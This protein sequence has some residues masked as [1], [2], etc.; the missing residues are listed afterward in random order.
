M[1]GSALINSIVRV[2]NARR[3][4]GRSS[5]YPWYSL[6]AL[7]I[8]RLE[9]PGWGRLAKFGLFGME[10]DPLWQGAPRRVVRGKWHGYVMDLDLSDWSQRQTYFL[11]R[12]HELDMQLLLNRCVRAG[13]RVVDVGANIGMVTL[14]AARIVGPHG[15][16]EAFEPNPICCDQI[17][18]L[19][20]QNGIGQVRLHRMGLSDV[21]DTLTLSVL[22]HHSGMGTLGRVTDPRTT[23]TNTFPVPVGIADEVLVSDER[24]VAVVKV[25]VEGFETR[26]LRGMSRTLRRWRPL[27]TTEVIPSWLERAGSSVAELADLMLGLGYR[28]F[29]MRTARRGLKHHL[30]LHPLGE[31]LS[32]EFLDVA[33]LPNS[34]QF[35]SW[36]LNA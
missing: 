33:W 2:N 29:G 34:R 26:V 32:P 35:D 13:D 31:S 27:V 36:L 4:G 21:S 24:P 12:Y 11:G 5:R 1:P 25:D 10:C 20:R 8:T 19:L 18:A 23:V 3:K 22:Q 14:H 16:V 6:L 30:E 15:L 17:A 9:L 28:A 7:P